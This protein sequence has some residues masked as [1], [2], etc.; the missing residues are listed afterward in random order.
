MI[1]E[2]ASGVQSCKDNTTPSTLSAIA[3]D[4]LVHTSNCALAALTFASMIF[5][6]CK[7]LGLGAR[8]NLSEVPELGG[9]KAD[10]GSFGRV[11]GPFRRTPT[12]GEGG[13]GRE[14][15]NILLKDI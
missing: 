13:G 9:L 11:L 12:P 14:D 15:M 4:S 2:A 6:G 10:R 7:A 8:G 3:A 1:S 5:E